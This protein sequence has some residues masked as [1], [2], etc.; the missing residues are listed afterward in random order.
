MSSESKSTKAKVVDNELVKNER[1]KREVVAII[2]AFNPEIDLLT[3]AITALQQQGSQIVVIDNASI[4]V[5]DLGESL[6]QIGSSHLLRQQQNLGLGAAHNL[7]IEYAT[8]LGADFVLI[9]DQ[10]SLPL[11]G[12][13]DELMAVHEAESKHVLVSAVGTSYLNSENGSKS[14]FVRFGGLKFQRHYCSDCT[15]AIEADFLI[16]SGSLISLSAID[17]VGLMDEQL[18]ID[19]VDTEW[20]L[21]ARSKGFKAFGSCRALMQ[22]GLGEN[23]HEVKIA[24]RKR[25]VPQHKPFRYYY[26]FRNSVLLYKRGYASA[27]WKWNDVQRL[28]LIMIMF[29]LLKAPRW[30][31]LS[32]MLKGIYHGLIGKQGAE[33]DA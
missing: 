32:M 7:G 10:D 29:G 21:R 24:G 3:K 33:P 23:T 27:L 5:D 26:I 4:N 28:V 2:V 8:G 30:R 13:V 16:S 25:N 20:F 17:E 6:N 31:N 19:H 14:F 12:M 1:V 18:F 11:E 22:H 15:Q 9:M